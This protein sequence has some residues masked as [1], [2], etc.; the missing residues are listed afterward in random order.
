MWSA[1]TSVY[2]YL[3]ACMHIHALIHMLTTRL[4]TRTHIQ[5]FAYSAYDKEAKG[6]SIYA[7]IKDTAEHFVEIAKKNAKEAAQL[8]VTCNPRVCPVFSVCALHLRPPLSTLSPFSP[9]PLCSSIHSAPLSLRSPFF[10]S[11]SLGAV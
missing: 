5:V 10:L 6:D 1:D 4:H 2:T 7:R 8:Y 11:H 9:L 3:L